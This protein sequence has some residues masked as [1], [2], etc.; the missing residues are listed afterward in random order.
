ML[1]LRDVM[2][3]DVFT[4]SP[5]V[6][7]REAVELLAANRV[8]GAPV[9]VGEKIVGTL[10]AN[11]VVAFIASIPGV[12]SLRQQEDPLL[13]DPVDPIGEG[14]G[15]SASY[16][17]DFWDDAGADV[18]ERFQT[19]VSPEWDV[20]DEHTVA[21]AMSTSA[22][23]L[24]PDASLRTAADH[25]QRSGVHRVLVGEGGRLLGIVSTMDITKAL[26]RN[27]LRER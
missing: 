4:L 12:P 1:T 10:S 16:F 14:A 22:L 8:T 3:D 6:S 20:L 9:I 26:A 2:T 19:V 24:A 23:L 5:E 21:E 27:L 11:D 18:A 7:L 17:T 25:M 15:P 13:Q